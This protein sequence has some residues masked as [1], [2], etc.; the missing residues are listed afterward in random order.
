MQLGDRQPDIEA[1]M[2][3]EE[4]QKIRRER[5]KAQQIIVATTDSSLEADLLKRMEPTY[6]EKV[7][8][9]NGCPREME[10]K[11]KALAIAFPE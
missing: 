3:R 11:A 7:G 6:G 4:T 9:D 1:E 5:R 10:I 8:K 2:V